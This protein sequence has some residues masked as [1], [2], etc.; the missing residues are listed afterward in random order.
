MSLFMKT[1]AK[2]T[3]SKEYTRS[4]KYF[5]LSILKLLLKYVGLAIPYQHTVVMG[6]PPITL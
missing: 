1:V 2:D 4:S 3:N 6:V 5:Q